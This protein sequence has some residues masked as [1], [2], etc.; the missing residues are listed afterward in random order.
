MLDFLKDEI[1]K[2]NDISDVLKN[3]TDDFLLQNQSIILSALDKTV[4]PDGYKIKIWINKEENTL[5]WIYVPDSQDAK[6]NEK[7][8]YM[9]TKYS[10]KLPNDWEKY[11]LIDLNDVHWTENKREFAA[12]CKKI[13]KNIDENNDFKG[14]WLYGI[15]NCGKTFGSIA[16]L[17]MIA[18]KN[19]SVS[20]VNIPDLILK[21]Q[22]SFKSSENNSDISLEKIIKSDVIV[23]DDLGSERPTPWFKENILLPIIDYRLKSNKPTIFNSNLN[24]GKYKNKLKFRSQNPEIEEE[25]NLKII[26]R[27]NDLIDEEIQIK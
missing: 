21:T 6:K 16:L 23:I 2:N 10:Y 12:I 11:Y 13:L 3:V 24:I 25:T 9:E 27:I 22:D 4:W 1:K 8:F 5:E 26:S 19:K 14:F 18:S 7:I 17:N 20:F 15:T